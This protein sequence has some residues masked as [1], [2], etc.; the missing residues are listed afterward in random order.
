MASSSSIQ[1]PCSADSTTPFWL[2]VVSAINWINTAI[3]TLSYFFI[4]TSHRS[5]V[6][7]QPRP[8]NKIKQTR[9]TADV[10]PNL[11]PMDDK[12]GVIFINPVLLVMG[13]RG[14]V[15]RQYQYMVRPQAPIVHAHKSTTNHLGKNQSPCVHILC[16]YLG[17]SF[18]IPFFVLKV[19][20][21][22]T[23]QRN[24]MPVLFTIQ[25]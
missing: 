20:P 5:E 3:L 11:S 22:N 16:K 23:F 9:V 24:T 4:K 10:N 17:F 7:V 19:V 6:Y 12:F 14:L 25:S 1:W 8:N 18:L 2:P 13:I 15:V 21:N